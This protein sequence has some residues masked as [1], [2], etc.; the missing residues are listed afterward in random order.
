MNI[1]T[2]L[3]AYAEKTYWTRQENN[4][5]YE[6]RLIGSHDDAIRG[7]LGECVYRV[8]FGLPVDLPVKKPDKYDHVQKIG[9]RDVTIEIKTSKYPR[10]TAYFLMPKW[11]QFIADRGILVR[12]IGDDAEVVGW[13]TREDFEAKKLYEWAKPS[14]AWTVG[15]GSLRPMEEWNESTIHH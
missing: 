14:P 7:V 3:K 1:S 15:E 12:I 13:L 2:D 4:V 6:S 9:G 5:N 11:K 8:Y 10:S